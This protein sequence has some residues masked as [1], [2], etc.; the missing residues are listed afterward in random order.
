MGTNYLLPNELLGNGWSLFWVRIASEWRAT[1]G[2]IE[3]AHSQY[4][5]LHGE[6]YF[7]CQNLIQKEKSNNLLV[8]YMEGYRQGSLNRAALLRQ[9]LELETITNNSYDGEYFLGLYGY[10]DG[11]EGN[12]I[13]YA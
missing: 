1:G 10:L 5:K 7:I 6:Y 12:A 3:T 4:R 9:G 8:A 13:R 11:M 2:T